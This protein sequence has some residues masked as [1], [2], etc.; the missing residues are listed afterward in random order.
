MSIIEDSFKRCRIQNIKQKEENLNV[1]CRASSGFKTERKYKK[2]RM[3]NVE[4]ARDSKYK[5]NRRTKSEC[6][7]PYLQPAR[8]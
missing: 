7:M 8:D 5:E 4:P 2:I 3:S 6:R 1:E